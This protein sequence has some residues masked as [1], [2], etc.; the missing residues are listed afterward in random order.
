MAAASNGVAAQTLTFS[1]AV[2]EDDDEVGADMDDDEDAVG[3]SDWAPGAA[4]APRS[5][6]EVLGLSHFSA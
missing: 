5:V 3:A 1:L 2:V 4:P 6:G